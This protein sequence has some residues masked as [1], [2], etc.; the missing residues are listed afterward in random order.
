MAIKKKKPSEEENKKTPE[1]EKEEE[2]YKEFDG[3]L[4]DEDLEAITSIDDDFDPESLG[5]KLDDYNTGYDPL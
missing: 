5:F 1:P 2:E 4:N 3:D